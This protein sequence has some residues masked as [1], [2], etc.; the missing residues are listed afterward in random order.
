MKRRT[1]PSVLFSLAAGALVLGAAGVPRAAVGHAG[2][3]WT[4]TI[5]MYAH[6]YT[7][8][9]TVENKD[10]LKAF[11]QVADAYQK[12]HPGVIINFVD[13]TYTDPYQTYRVKAAA[14]EMFDI[15]WGQ[16][17]ALNSTLPRG[18]AVDLTPYYKQ[19]N[20]YILGNTAWQNA[21]NAT[22]VNETQAPNG[23]HYNINGDFVGTAFFYNKDLFKKAGIS[24]T[25]STW[26]QLLADCAKLKKAGITPVTGVPLHGWFVRH[27]LS[28]F[29]AQDF[30]KIVGYGGKG[31]SGMSALDEAVAIKKGVLSA[32]DP[33]FLAWWPIF[34][35]LAGY[36]DKQYLT[37]D[38]STSDDPTRQEFI[39]GQAGIY[40]S[41]SWIPNYLKNAKVSF[42]WGTFP[43]PTLNK[44]VSP[45]AHGINTAGY[46]GGPNADYQY[47][48]STPKADKSMA[49]PGKTEA[50][51]DWLRY[52][53]TPTVLQQVVNEKGTYVPT[54]P[55]TKPK[56]GGNGTF[57]AEAN[58]TLHVITI[59]NA[60]A[61]EDPAIQKAFS[62]YLGGDLSI[63]QA[64]TQVQAALDAAA[65][66]FAKTNGVDLSKY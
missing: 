41:G 63:Q 51:L 6:D 44:A 37:Q 25:P 60:S 65:N 57:A 22:V 13:Q 62:L 23:A 17:A 46:V 52:I 19:K 32:K 26:Q 53:G 14:G 54:W 61:Q 21:M 66:D 15:W 24:G 58:Q 7:P 55:G 39:S 40:Y 3:T 30:S 34:K 49:Q 56:G 10:N 45:Y 48:I 27:W 8:N 2:A 29:Y 33:R 12:S 18:I 43:W 31:S 42:T 59:G 47:A 36:W 9:S 4:G 64:K 35:G 38:T 28:D 11:R 1:K 16:W 20:P 5:T 50:V